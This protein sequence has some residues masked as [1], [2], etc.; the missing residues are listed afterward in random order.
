MEL[1]GA[2]TKPPRWYAACTCARHEKQVSRQLQDRRIECFLPL[3]RSLRRWKDRRKELELPLFPGYIFVHIA[4]EDRLRILQVPSVVRF[5]GFNG[6]PT[7][8]EDSE[9]EQLRNGILNGVLAEPH[10]YLKLGSRVRVKHGPLAGAEGIL[11]R[12]KDTC[13][14]VLSVE[15]LMRSVAVEVQAA[16]LE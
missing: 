1:E 2:S 3:Y 15:L 14:I 6:Q 9:V 13:R 4:C 16:D 10:P 5:V 7:A 8:L 12:K 11:I